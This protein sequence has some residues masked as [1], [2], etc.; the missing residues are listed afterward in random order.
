MKKTY[1]ILIL[2]IL[3]CTGCRAEY[4]LTINEDLTVD[5]EVRALETEEFF[6]QYP[7][8]SVSRVIELVMS[9]G[10]DYLNENSYTVNKIIAYESGAKITKRFENFDDYYNTSKFYTQLFSSFDYEKKGNIIS[11]KLEGEMSRELNVV[12]RYLVDEATI[13]IRVRT[14]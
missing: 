10:Q 8:S 6:E 7:K 2:L 4:T 3:V 13:S 5:E 12:D 1:L 11:I 14:F 9:M